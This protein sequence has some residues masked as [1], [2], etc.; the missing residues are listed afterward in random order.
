[1]TVFL[2]QI[3]LDEKKL[4]ISVRNFRRRLTPK[5]IPIHMA[6]IA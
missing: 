4:G 3:V 2:V 1:V 5:P 6:R